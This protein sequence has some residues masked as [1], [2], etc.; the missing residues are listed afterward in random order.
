MA[1]PRSS[2]LELMRNDVEPLTFS[3][4]SALADRDGEIYMPFKLLSRPPLLIS[5]YFFCQSHLVADV[6]L[7]LHP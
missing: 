4:L 6:I 5:A 2:A 3:H 7:R 1:W